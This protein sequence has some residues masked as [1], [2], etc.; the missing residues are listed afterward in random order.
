M[1]EVQLVMNRLNVK[2]MDTENIVRAKAVVWLEPG[3]SKG[4]SMKYLSGET[5]WEFC[6]TYRNNIEFAR[7]MD[8][9]R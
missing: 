6:L 9:A 8:S 4:M 1:K 5:P 3:L 7:A 2:M